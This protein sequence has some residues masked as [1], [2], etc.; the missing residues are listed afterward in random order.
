[1]EH[2]HS[3]EK[4]RFTGWGNSK[5]NVGR[6][7]QVQVIGTGGKCL[8]VLAACLGI[9]SSM[10]ARKKQLKGLGAHT[11]WCWECLLSHDLSYFSV[12]F[13]STN[14]VVS[15]VLQGIQDSGLRAENH[16]KKG[17]ETI[18]HPTKLAFD[19][20]WVWEEDFCTCASP[21][22]CLCLTSLVQE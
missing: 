19:S 13:C 22:Y 6:Y 10:E 18:W 16:R 11:V 20:E 14:A 21:M 8:G 7:H 9:I 1:M 2:M 15:L 3:D 17:R 5:G 4:G 12:C